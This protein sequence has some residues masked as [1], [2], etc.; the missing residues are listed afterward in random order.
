MWQEEDNGGDEGNEEYI[1]QTHR[2]RV[3][4]ELHGQSGPP[5]RQGQRGGNRGGKPGSRAASHG[6]QPMKADMP[7]MPLLVGPRGSAAPSK[8]PT[9]ASKGAVELFQNRPKPAKKASPEK[10]ANEWPEVSKIPRKGR[11]V[12]TQ[13]KE[14]ARMLSSQPSRVQREPFVRAPVARAAE[15][16]VFAIV[17]CL[18]S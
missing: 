6:R 12:Y 2:L 3:H 4:Q 5:G 14:I 9:M 13:E 8:K 17:I 18:L 7:S 16:W 11:D 1:G 15:E 10:M